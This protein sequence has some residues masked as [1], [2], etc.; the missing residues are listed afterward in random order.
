MLTSFDAE[1]V[2]LGAA[3][4][5]SETDVLAVKLPEVPVIVTG[6]LF[7][8]VAV[9]LALSVRVL[10]PVAGF[11]LNDAVT[12]LGSPDAENVTLALKPFCGVTVIVLEPDVP[13]TM[14]TL[15]E[16]ERVYLG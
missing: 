14:L 5:V 2:K 15:F 16:A 6:T 3:V 12:P 10:K 13:C 4:T 8:V 11:G 9:L 1:S 7:P